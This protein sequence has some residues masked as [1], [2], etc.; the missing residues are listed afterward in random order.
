MRNKAALPRRAMA[1]AL[2]LAAAAA[3]ASPARAAV[4]WDGLA[5]DA[6][7]Q[8]TGNWPSNK[9]PTSTQVAEFDGTGAYN[10]TTAA[11][12]D[13]GGTFSL[14]EIQFA[15]AANGTTPPISLNNSALNG[16]ITL[17]GATGL[18]VQAKQTNPVTLNTNLSLFP[19]SGTTTTFN[20]TELTTVNGVIG[21]GAALLDTGSA[22]LVLTGQNTYSGGTNVSGVTLQLGSSST[23]S[24][25]SIASGPI[26]PGALTLATGSTLKDTGGSVSIANAVSLGG[27]INFATTGGGNIT[28]DGTSLSAPNGVTLTSGTT[29]NVTNTTTINSAIG[30]GGNA[31]ALTKTG[32]GTLALGGA[33]N[34]YSGGTN[35]NTGTLQLGASSTIAS[36]VIASGPVGVGTLTLAGGT[37]LKDNNT[38]ITLANAVS[39]GGGTVN[40]GGP[41]GSITIDGTALNSPTGVSLTASTTLNVTD[42]TTIN[43]PI[44]DGG[45][46]YSLIKTG[47]AVLKL[48]G[49]NT[50]T[51]T[52]TIDQ[53]NI[54]VGANAPSGGAGALGNSTTPIQVGDASTPHT[55]GAGLVTT[56][57]FTV[58]RDISVYNIAANAGYTSGVITLGGTT[59]QTGSTSTFS[60]TVTL[61]GPANFQSYT[62]GSKVVDFPGQ[63]TGVGALNKTG[64]GTVQLD[65][66]NNNYSGGTTVTA[67]T[68]LVNGSNT[69]G[70]TFA[71]T[72][73][74]LGGTGSIV[75]G[76]GANGL[77]VA[78]GA[79]IAPGLL[80]SGPTSGSSLNITGDVAINGIL[81]IEADT[82]TSQLNASGALA[83]GANSTLVFTGNSSGLS[84][85]AYVIATYGASGLSGT[86]GS[87]TNE[88]A[89]YTLDYDY[90]GNNEIALVDPAPA[91]E[92]AAVSLFCVATFG[93]L[94]RRRNRFGPVTPSSAPSGERSGADRM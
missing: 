3:F 2:A 20:I 27:T 37:T 79:T 25:R 85:F 14:S 72:A 10:S 67:G 34:T 43:S 15:S 64:T 78:S 54:Q 6:N 93:L 86:F 69:G 56:G 89:G 11:T 82:N 13:A 74:T 75:T 68:L 57:H 83:L 60:G 66:T 91:P 70:G 61:N 42:T 81:S 19:T 38:P 31:F 80:A 65:N 76:G 63:I 94:G 71:A 90:Q 51:G 30:D 29:A 84:A 16:T 52:T 18:F 4:I 28:I 23:I 88:P 1:T 62:S 46:G 58:G 53:N 17:T 9:L 39:L 73:G 36:G 26:G 40:F 33:N 45:N 5:G 59:A 32:T 50:Y 44:G 41:G 48:A 49:S 24:A 21:G 22:A 8:T 92:P 35:L 87:I 12:I 55:A 7:W 77:T 47:D